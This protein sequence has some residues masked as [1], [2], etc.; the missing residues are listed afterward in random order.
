MSLD[1]WLEPN[2]FNPSETF[3]DHLQAIEAELPYLRASLGHLADSNNAEGVLQLSVA[4]AVFWHIRGYL[5]ENQR[6][7]RRSVDRAGDARTAVL[8]RALVVLSLI[9][10]SLG[11]FEAARPLAT[12]ALA[13]VKEA[14]DREVLANANL[15]LGLIEGNTESMVYSVTTDCNGRRAVHQPKSALWIVKHQVSRHP[16]NQLFSIPTGTA[17]G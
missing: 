1:Y 3:N 2:H 9:V 6:W 14:G 8:T 10:W 16:L 4:L 15:E 12:N 5:H 17:V 7:L 13:S 11:D